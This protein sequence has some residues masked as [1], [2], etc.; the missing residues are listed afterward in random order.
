MP[1]C[2][3][4]GE[5]KFSSF[6]VDDGDLLYFDERLVN[7][8][9]MRENML[10]AMNFGH[11][12]RDAMLREVAD[13]WWPRNH[14]EIVDKANNYPEFSRGYKNVKFLKAENEYGKLPIAEKPNDEISIDY[15]GPF[16]NAKKN[17]KFLL[18]SVDHNL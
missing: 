2:H 14:S 16:Q 10:N 5:R 9:N 11:A 17:K 3:H 4:H 12:G 18:V 13:V 7:P 15:A 8:K 6:G 1:D